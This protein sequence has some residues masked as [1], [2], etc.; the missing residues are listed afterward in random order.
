MTLADV[1]GAQHVAGNAATTA[2]LQRQVE[3]PVGGSASGSPATTPGARPT[4][5][6]GSQGDDVKLLQMKLRQVREREFDRDVSGRARIDGMF[7]PLTRQDVLDF[8]SDTGL[9]ADGIAGPRTWDALDS[10]VPGTPNQAVEEGLD[11]AF[12]AAVDLKHAGRYEEALPVFED[13]IA[14]S[15]TPE[16]IGPAA[17]NAGVCHQQRGRFGLAVARYELALTGRFNQE[18]LRAKLLSDLMLARQNQFL[19]DPPPDPEPLPPGAERGE[20]A[21]SEGGGITERQPVKSGDSGPNADL[22]KG[23]LAHAMVGWGPPM[24]AGDTIDGA[25]IA[26]TREFQEAC[27]LAQTGEGDASTWHALDTFSHADVPFSVVRP[28]WDRNAA[29]SSVA[30]SDPAAGLPMLEANR[31]EGRSLGLPEDAKLT[32]AQIGRTHHYLEHFAEAVE[33]YNVFL[34]RN[35]PNPEQLALTT[36]L[37]GRARRGLPP[38]D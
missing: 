27:G 2:L 14:T 23:K 17:A 3:A 10:L 21:G 12:L 5:R 6:F 35:I 30:R 15:T 1:L 29:A 28:H 34:S 11:D 18:E 22:Y 25:T 26:R 32:E 33:H 31:D 20:V 9:D 38:P 4:L 37:L 24:P 19:D 8:Q 13:L 7:G 16:M 36:E